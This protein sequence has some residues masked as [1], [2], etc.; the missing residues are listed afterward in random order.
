MQNV[1][2]FGS[3]KGGVNVIQ[4]SVSG[5]TSLMREIDVSPDSGVVQQRLGPARVS[6]RA[7][8]ILG[9]VEVGQ[10]FSFEFRVFR[11]SGVVARN[12]RYKV[13]PGKGLKISGP[14]EGVIKRLSR[15]KSVRVD[16]I[17]V[18]EGTKFV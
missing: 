2:P 14:D 18:S 6:I 10:P 5:D 16:A 12:V 11:S 13:L 15:V 1:V 4:A 3:I 17:S 8:R 9:R 7:G